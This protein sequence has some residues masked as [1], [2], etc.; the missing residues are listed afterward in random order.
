MLRRRPRAPQRNA[1]LIGLGEQVGGQADREHPLEPRDLAQQRLKPGRAGISAQLREQARA[2]AR[3]L[4]GAIGGLVFGDELLEPLH[5][6]L[7]KSRDGAG[8][9]PLI[10]QSSCAAQQPPDPPRRLKTLLAAARQQR[11]ALALLSQLAGTDLVGQPARQPFIGP[12]RLPKPGRF[13]D[14]RAVI[15]DRP[16]RPFV[17]LKLACLDLHQAGDVINGRR[18]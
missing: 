15:L 10:R 2:S 1:L 12:G 3:D 17:L 5:R 6:P 14:L 16:T 13:P 4:A 18:R 9:E 11:R 8:A 7:V